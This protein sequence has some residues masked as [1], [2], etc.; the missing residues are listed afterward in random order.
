M[1]QVEFNK[2]DELTQKLPKNVLPKRDLW[3]KIVPRLHPVT[4]TWWQSRVWLAAAGVFL[5]VTSS[6]MTMLFTGAGTGI[7]PR[8]AHEAGQVAFIPARLTGSAGLGE[9]YRADRIVLVAEFERSLA[10]LS[11]ETRNSV[12]ANL[13]E[14]QRTLAEING[15]LEHDPNNTLLH[16]MMVTSYTSE[17]QLLADVNRLS[18]LRREI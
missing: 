5:V 10:T 11:P 17:M 7:Q 9:K 18:N 1:K 6:L 15:L 2:L 12:L 14:I 4:G 8:V 3:S 13:Q 16:Q